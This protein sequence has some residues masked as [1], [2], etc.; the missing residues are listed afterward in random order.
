MSPS[1]D[2]V[3]DGQIETQIKNNVDP[4]KVYDESLGQYLK[5]NGLN[6]DCLITDGEFE[7]IIHEI[8]NNHEFT[9]NSIK[10]ESHEKFIRALPVMKG[11]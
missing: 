5:L 4:E 3:Q 8:I 2:L 6:N 11:R 9:Y 1:E 7:R 10:L